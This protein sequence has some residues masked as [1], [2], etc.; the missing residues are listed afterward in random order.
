MNFQIAQWMVT[1]ASTVL[2]T[3]QSMILVPLMS[4]A[5]QV[6]SHL[7]SSKCR[8]ALW[9]YSDPI[10]LTTPQTQSTIEPSSCIRYNDS[11][12]SLIAVDTASQNLFNTCLFVVVNLHNTESS[13]SNSSS[14]LDH[15]S[16]RLRIP[17][18]SLGVLFEWCHLLIEWFKLCTSWLLS[19]KNDFSWLTLILL[20][21]GHVNL[22]LNS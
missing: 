21:H 12:I 13:G 9:V 18:H 11:K 4:C 3:M 6:W 7:C 15:P 19:S 10:K 16:R 14:G 8:V 1:V 22:M 5:L 2:N 17:P 20:A